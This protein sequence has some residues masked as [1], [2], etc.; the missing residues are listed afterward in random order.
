[1]KIESLLTKSS[2]CDTM[3]LSTKA[4]N[5]S[6]ITKIAPGIKDQNRVNISINDKF[7]CSLDISQLAD[8][9]LKIGQTLDDAKLAEL[10][11]A[12]DFGKLYTRTLEFTLSRP[13]SER[14]IRDYLYKK[15]RDRLIRIK[16]PKTNTYKTI[17]RPGYDKTLV[18]PVLDRLT[19]KGHID[20]QKFAQFW[21]EHRHRA[22]GIS[23]RR[24]AGELQQKGIAKDAIDHVLQSS[25]RNESAE[26]A[27][28]ITKKRPRYPDDHKLIAYLLRQGFPYDD[29]LAQVKNNS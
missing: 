22:K 5:S 24:L 4:G 25:P 27:K 10:R 8:L 17:Q 9:K 19:A 18:Q 6:R 13:H 11:S 21:A 14:E 12:S 26:L 23:T 3:E 7:F 20:D 2:E 16:D 1:M 28:I 29:I 15:T